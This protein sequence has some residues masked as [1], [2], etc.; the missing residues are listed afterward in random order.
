MML[1]GSYIIIDVTLRHVDIMCHTVHTF[2]TH[3]IEKHTMVVPL[4]A[5]STAGWTKDPSN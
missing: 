4:V 3:C 5:Q 2:K 1:L